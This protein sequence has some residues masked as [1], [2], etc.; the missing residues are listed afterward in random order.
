M[1][2]LGET[3]PFSLSQDIIVDLQTFHPPNHSK[4][5]LSFVDMGVSKNRG[6][7]KSSILIGFSPGFPLFSPSILGSLIFG[8][9]HMTSSVCPESTGSIPNNGHAP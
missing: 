2:Q 9:T 8:N 1:K 6:T 5:I 4:N 3:T 7:P